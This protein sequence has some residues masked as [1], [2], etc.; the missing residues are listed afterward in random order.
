MNKLEKLARKHFSATQVRKPDGGLTPAV[1]ETVSQDKIEG[2]IA[3]F[4]MAREMCASYKDSHGW[5]DFMA[6]MNADRMRLI[7]EEDEVD[8]QS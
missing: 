1:G 3:G 8:P 6:K 2:F 5:G 4:R 7:G